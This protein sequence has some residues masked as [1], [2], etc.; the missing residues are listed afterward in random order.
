MLGEGGQVSENID[1]RDIGACVEHL[2]REFELEKSSVR[3]W[4]S[5]P[6]TSLSVLAAN[7]IS[8]FPTTS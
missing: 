2:F 8:P 5:L 4:T 6:N 7:A 3:I 1:V